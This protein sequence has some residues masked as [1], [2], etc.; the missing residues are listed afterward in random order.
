MVLYYV[1]GWGVSQDYSMA[2]YWYRKSAEQGDA[3]AQ[4]NLGNCYYYGT[5]VEKDLD[6]AKKWWISAAQ[7]ENAQAIRNLYNLLGIKWYK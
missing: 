2:V 7:Q 4:L 5:G 1:K 3:G 6:E